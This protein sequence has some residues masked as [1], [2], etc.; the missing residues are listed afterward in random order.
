[1][2]KD[3]LKADDTFNNNLKQDDMRKLIQIEKLCFICALLCGMILSSCTSKPDAMGTKGDL[4]IKSEWVKEHLLNADPKLPFSFIYDGKA[5]SELLKTWQ[6]KAETTILDSNRTQYTHIWTDTKTGLEVRS[7]AVD[8]SD[9]S[10]VEWT[11]YFRNTGTDNTPVLK[12]IQ[13]LDATFNR[14]SNDE[15]VLNGIKGDFCTEDSYEPYQLTLGPDFIKKFAPLILVELHIGSCAEREPWSQLS[16]KSQRRFY[17]K[18]I[19]IST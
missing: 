14:G 8:Y 17:I 12:E 11:V 10:A 4:K 15:F 18:I 6:K 1:M 2:Y 19:D 5:S 3:E 9:Y 7:V 13:G 16:H